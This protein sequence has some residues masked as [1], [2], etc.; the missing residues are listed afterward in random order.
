MSPHL[1]YPFRSETA[2]ILEWAEAKAQNWK[3]KY[4][5]GLIFWS[6]DRLDLAQKY[7]AACGDV[8]D[9]APFYLTRGNMVRSESPQVA[10]KDYKRALDLGSE[11][12]RTYHR[13]VE[14]YNERGEL[15]RALEMA[16]AGV[17]RI[18]SSYV[19]QLG[20]AKALLFNRQYGASLSILDTI[21]ILP[22]EGARYGHEIH[23][24]VSILSASEAM[25][26]GNYPAAIKLLDKAR[27]WPERLGAGRSYDVDDRLEDYLEALCYRKLGDRAAARKLFEKVTR[28][29][30]EHATD[31]GV[32]RLIAALALRELGRNVEG[33]KMIDDWVKRDPKNV[34]A[35]WSSL[36]FARERGQSQK[37]E[38][39]MRKGF[40]GS[41]LSKGS[42]DANFALIVE[43]H[44]I[45][46]L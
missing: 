22:S 23:R 18:P 43:I 1:V 13:L 24:Q 2:E 45:L 15:A 16:R 17:S 9:Y 31:W 28:Y 36:V 5:L 7:F 37:L 25:K 26:N 19:L 8:P 35:K 12:S 29:T 27:Q 10:L 4:Y 32:H 40:R 44:R 33:R 11:A 38:S 41:L 3:T 6:K 42:V 34:A 20:W 46:E 21:T 30:Q 14:Y 39:E